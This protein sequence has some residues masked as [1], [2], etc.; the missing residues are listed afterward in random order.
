MKPVVSVVV[1]TCRR[2]ESL[3]R[4]LRAL[5]AQ[6]LPAD[7]FEIIVVDD[8]SEGEVRRMV[9]QLR[10]Q[11]RRVRYRPTLGEHGPIVARNLG[12]Q[13]AHAEIIAF[14]D[15]DCLPDPGWLTAGLAA[16]RSGADAAAGRLLVPLPPA[17]TDYERELASLERSEFL[18]ANCFCRREA[19]KLVG[20]FDEMFRS[21]WGKDSDL[22]F[23]LVE[24]GCDVVR[25]DDAVVV[26]PVRPGRWGASLLLQ[27]KAMYDELLCRKHPMLYHVR[28]E[29]IPTSYY[30]ITGS[31]GLAAFSAAMAPSWFAV[32]LTVWGTLTGAFV[33]RRLRGSSHRPAHIAETLVTSAMI[34]PMTLFW[35]AWGQWRFRSCGPRSF[36]GSV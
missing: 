7:Q 22:H 4:C 18:S 12:W 30:A 25:A 19:L 9:R 27:S 3:E 36:W 23:S 16:L 11:G 21:E 34:P 32:A 24:A 1:A 14:T 8:A 20:G 13:V 31:I 33:W 35:H 26:H 15:D 5:L 29:P 28:S 6:D 17:P 2:R 10:R